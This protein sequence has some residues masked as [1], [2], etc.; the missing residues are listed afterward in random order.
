MIS[1]KLR[2]CFTTHGTQ[3][4]ILNNKSYIKHDN[5]TFQW[6][7]RYKIEPD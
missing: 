1:A 7:F 2:C 6:G 5:M 3:A 4:S